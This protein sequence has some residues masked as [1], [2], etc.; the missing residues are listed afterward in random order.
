MKK[1]M[2]WWVQSKMVS[3]RD[4]YLSDIMKELNKNYD[5]NFGKKEES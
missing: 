3:Q 4:A 2:P 1:E 5:L